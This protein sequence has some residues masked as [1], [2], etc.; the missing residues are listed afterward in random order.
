MMI[1][2]VK[3]LKILQ[4][5][6]DE[7][8]RVIPFHSESPVFIKWLRDTEIAI[9]NIFTSETRHWKDFGA[10]D[11]YSPTLNQ[12]GLSGRESFAAGLNLAQTILQSFMVSFQKFMDSQIRESW[13]N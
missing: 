5:Q 6:I 13:V 2:K 11:F 10:I 4:R 1:L 9:D 12:E 3:A 8:A 7:I